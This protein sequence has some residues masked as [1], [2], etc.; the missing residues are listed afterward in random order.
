MICYSHLKSWSFT[1]R[2]EPQGTTADAPLGPQLPHLR[3][4][5]AVAPA[6]CCSPRSACANLVAPGRAR[7]LGCFLGLHM[8]DLRMIRVFNRAMKQTRCKLLAGA[9]RRE[10][11]DGN[12]RMGLS[13]NNYHGSFPHSLLSTSKTINYKHMYAYCLD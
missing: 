2:T 10:W 9:E 11:M 4:L 6:W 3:C 5:G 13:L 7:T 1:A 12:G 8:Q